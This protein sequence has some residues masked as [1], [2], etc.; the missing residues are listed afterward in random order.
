MA[1]LLSRRGL[2]PKPYDTLAAPAELEARA[3]PP[4]VLAD[5]R[6]TADGLD[7][8]ADAVQEWTVGIF[9]SVVYPATVPLL[10]Q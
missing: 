7:A 6:T 2:A 8:A 4:Q 1:G 10:L 9:Q 5:I 3:E